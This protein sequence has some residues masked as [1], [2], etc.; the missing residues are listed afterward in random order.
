[1]KK[2]PLDLCVCVEEGKDRTAS[3]TD[4]TT[5]VVETLWTAQLYIEANV[6]IEDALSKM[7]AV[8]V[9]VAPSTLS[10]DAGFGLF[11]AATIPAGTRV[12]W[13]DGRL[14]GT[15][16][17]DTLR[18]RGEAT[19]VAT[20]LARCLYV[21]GVR[22]VDAFI[23]TENGTPTDGLVVGLASVA[24]GE[25]TRQACNAR[26]ARQDVPARLWLV[27]TRELAAGEEILVWYGRDY[28]R[29]HLAGD[30]S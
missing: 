5:K 13:Y 27:A 30:S 22:G 19:H 20:V 1:M 2:K 12:T 4:R 15:R 10:G 7:S 9:R 29:R 14:L 17:A 3:G 18:R 11:A 28:L 23:A 16:E 21:D 24:N 6:E 25:R 26:F 8:S